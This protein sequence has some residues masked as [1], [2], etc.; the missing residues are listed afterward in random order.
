[1]APPNPDQLLGKSLEGRTASYRLV[2]YLSSGGIA[3][4]YLAESKH[5]P[6]AVKLLR[7]ELLAS[8]DIVSRFEREA[9]F[10]QRIE[11]PSVLRVIEG[12]AR[13]APWVFFVC[14]HLTGVDVA[15]LIA[16][17]RRIPVPR[18]LKISIA[19]AD[20]LAA[21][22]ANGLIHRDVKPENIF[23]CHLPDGRE[24]VKILDFG[25]AALRGAVREDV[26][27]VG[28]PGYASPE[29]SHNAP[30]DEPADVYGLGVVLYEMLAGHPPF[31]AR[32]WMDL[33]SLHALSPPPPIHGLAPSVDRIVR[34]ALSKDPAERYPSMAAFSEAK[35]AV[36]ADLAR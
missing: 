17:R 1:M 28:T 12:I 27:F 16:S 4:V 20:G 18:A 11:H 10:A 22:H 25:A 31:S 26:S 33:L 3:H 34:T 5:G 36:L 14:E 15:D 9:S 19:A 6:V 7:P 13:S 35:R 21:A 24:T 32:N 29:Q 30:P 23:L 8:A 2:R